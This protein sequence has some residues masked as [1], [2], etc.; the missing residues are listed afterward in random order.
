MPITPT[1][2]LANYKAWSATLTLDGEPYTIVDRLPNRSMGFD[3][4]RSTCSVLVREF[5]NVAAGVPAVVSVTLNGQTET[6]FTGRVAERPIADLPRS[7]EVSLVD[8]LGL[9]DTP[10]EDALTWSNTDFDDAVREVL[11]AAGIDNSQIASIHNPGSLFKLGPVYAITVDAGTTARQVLDTLMAF[12]GTGIFTLANGQVQIRDFPGWG[13]PTEDNPVY[14]Y[15]RD[16][17]L[18]E[19]GIISSRRTLGGFE[20][21]VARFKAYGP[22]RPDLAIPDATFTLSGVTGSTVEEAYEFIQTDATAGAVAERD[23]VRRNHNYTPVDVTAPSNPLLLPGDDLWFRNTILGYTANTAAIVRGT[24]INDVTMTLS[25]GV[26]GEPAAGDVEFTP[27]PVASFELLYEREPIVLAGVP[28]LHT[29]VQAKSTASDPSGF[30]IVAIAWTATA[31]EINGSAAVSPQSASWNLPGVGEPADDT[32]KNPV[33]VF[34][35]LDGAAITMTVTSASGEGHTTTQTLTPTDAEVFTRSLSVAAGSAGWKVLA[36]TTGWRTFAGGTCT[37]V[38]RINDSGPMIAGFSNG[39]L[40]QTEDL[41]ATTPILVYDFESSISCLF[42]NEGTGTIW[43][44]GIGSTLWRT[45]DAGATWGIVDT[46][47]GGITYAESSPD[48]PD[49]IRVCAGDT[50]WIALDGGTFVE[51]I[52]GP[53]DSKAE[54]FAS[55]PWGHAVVFSGDALLPADLVAFEEAGLTVDW[56]GVPVGDRPTELTAITALLNVAGFLVAAGAAKDIIRDGIYSELGYAAISGTESA[57]YKLVLNGMVFVAS[58]LAKSTVTGAHKITTTGGAFQIDTVAATQIG[59]GGWVN[60]PFPPEMIVVPASNNVFLHYRPGVGFTTGTM[61]ITGGWSGVVINP[62][63]QNEWIAWIEGALFFGTDILARAFLTRNSGAS[64]VEIT[65]LGTPYGDGKVINSVAWA[66]IG[67]QWM[68]TQRRQDES[69]DRYHALNYRGDG[70]GLLD[71]TYQ[72]TGT[73]GFAN[74]AAATTYHLV[75]GLAGEM[76]G[77]RSTVLTWRTFAAG[78]ADAVDL[79]DSPMIPQYV[80]PGTRQLIAILNSNIGYTA[81]YSTTAPAPIVS[82]GGSSAVWVA[83]GVYVGGATDGIKR[84]TDLLG[85]PVVS[86]VAAAGLTVGPVQAGPKRIAVGALA[87]AGGYTHIYGYNGTTWASVALPGGYTYGNAYAM[88]EP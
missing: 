46:F 1:N 8:V 39:K 36:G 58:L 66:G 30:G 21:R 43:L 2:L 18:G 22:Q 84:I 5:P 35:H 67:S 86:T 55:A 51:E 49:E 19:F 12:G 42:I 6:F 63:K 53:E 74:A 32:G 38:P 16:A 50:L 7:F 28:T 68:M 72:T 15:G 37:A 81:N 41:L 45:D 80:I 59:Y 75:A 13:S 47:P 65:E 52:V 62:V 20:G 69:N 54:G 85:T 4:A 29:V 10:L 82:G 83:D 3:Q 48:N 60:L 87:G 27:P 24:N 56:S 57:I 31:T 79:Y 34:K 64:W 71:T 76:V 14:A 26:G 9:L 73:G 17:S 33:F 23:I 11:N 25:L 61:P 70:I 88:I 44:A 77:R 78:T 40:Y